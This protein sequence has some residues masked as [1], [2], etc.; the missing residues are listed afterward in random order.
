MINIIIENRSP[1][2]NPVY[3]KIY[4]LWHSMM[5]RCYNPNAKSFHNYGGNGVTVSDDW[6][7]LDGFI[8]TIDKVDGFDLD[9]VLKGE[10]QLDKDM[11]FKGNKVYSYQNCMFVTLQQN[12]ANRRNNRSFVA[13]NLETEEVEVTSNRE[14]FCRIRNL[15]SSTIW[16][17][18]QKNAGKTV[19]KAPNIYKDWVF[20][21]ED[22]FSILKL[23]SIDTY[24]AIQGDTQILFTNQ[25][26]FSREYG[27]N[28]TSVAACIKGRQ[29]KAGDYYIS[30]YNTKHYKD[31]TTIERQ[32]IA[33][34]VIS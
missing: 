11:K 12:S 27:L 10:L 2:Y 18:L 8:E 17:M 30:L 23:P 22:G 14:E 33:L 25:R 13:I 6:L 26:K 31:S 5:L 1:K 16:R 7:A 21:Y 24:Q 29:H 15:D 3:K 32:L 34:G 9:L 4:T 28:A 20:Q 19:K